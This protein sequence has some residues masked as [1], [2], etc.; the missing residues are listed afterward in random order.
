[1]LFF[2]SMQPG[3]APTVVGLVSLLL[4]GVTWLGGTSQQQSYMPSG[5]A[6]LKA[7]V[8]CVPAGC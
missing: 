4:W 6:V 7:S 5:K 3:C 1:M 2:D 8:L